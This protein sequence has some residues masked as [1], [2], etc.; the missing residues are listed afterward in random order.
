MSSSHSRI[1]PRL[2]AWRP[3]FV[4]IKSPEI[5]QKKGDPN[6]LNQHFNLKRLIRII[7]VLEANQDC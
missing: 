3:A 7:H 1:L 4:Q 6:N 2:Q 5:T